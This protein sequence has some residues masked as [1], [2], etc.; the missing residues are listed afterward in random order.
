MVSC[1][2]HFLLLPFLY[3]FFSFFSFFSFFFLLKVGGAFRPGRSSVFLQRSERRGD[4]A[5]SFRF[6]LLWLGEKRQ[7]FSSWSSAVFSLLFSTLFSHPSFFSVLLFF[8][9]VPFSV[10]FLPSFS[11]YCRLS[12]SLPSLFRSLLLFLPCRFDSIEGQHWPRKLPTSIIGLK[13]IPQR[14]AGKKKVSPLNIRKGKRQKHKI[15]SR[16]RESM[17]S[18]LLFG[19]TFLWFWPRITFICFPFFFV[20]CF[21]I[22]ML[23]V[24]F[25]LL[26]FLVPFPSP[27]VSSSFFSFFN[28]SLTPFFRSL[29]AFPRSNNGWKV[30]LLL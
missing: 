29:A 12:L 26:S 3:A 8:S 30:L 24:S 23:N 18:T 27:L 11:S 14:R 10:F 16:E 22:H 7:S 6:L 9:F 4:E 20:L 13:K 15:I 28:C 21:F 19:F 25:Y 1:F 2:P 5:A 17:F